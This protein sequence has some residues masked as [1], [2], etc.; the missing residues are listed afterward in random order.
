M[1]KIAIVIIL[2]IILTGCHSTERKAD[3]DDV[4]NLTS[5][6]TTVSLPTPSKTQTPN[7]TITP[8][9]GTAWMQ[10]YAK[11]IVDVDSKPGHIRLI[12]VDFD[13]IP[14]LFLSYTGTSNSW[15][16]HGFSFKSGKIFEISIPDEI[17][18]TEI[19]LYK[20]RKT[21][22]MLWVANGMFRNGYGSYDYEWYKVDFSDF[23]DVKKDF[24]FGWNESGSTK[25]NAKEGEFV[26]ALIEKNENH[27]EM[28]QEEIENTKSK[29]FSDYVKIETLELFSYVDDFKNGGDSLTE[30]NFN[31]DRFYTFLNLYESKRQSNSVDNLSKLN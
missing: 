12:D 19:E 27:I 17:M 15:I 21:N 25:S 10:A 7:P 3:A 20:N 28:S 8:F 13:G 6:Q 4:R 23:S 14:E 16:Y 18:P 5:V 29:V 11:V 2:L 26:Y 30:K 9:V 1:K 22:E 24:F 31:K